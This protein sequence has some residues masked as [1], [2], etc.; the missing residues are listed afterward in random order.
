MAASA[1]SAEELTA[2]RATSII[3]CPTSSP[4][5][6]GCS[7]STC[8]VARPA[9]RRL[10]GTEQLDA[11]ADVVAGY[12]GA[13][14][15]GVASAG[16][17]RIWT[18]PNRSRA[19]WR[20]R[21]SAR[22]AADRVQVLTVHAAKGLEWQLVAVPHLSGRVFPSTA[23]ARTWLTDAGDL[24]PLLRGDRARSARTASRCSTPRRSTD[25]KQLSDTITGHRDELAQRRIDE[26]R[27]LLYV[28]ITRAEDTLLL[29]GHQWGDTELKPRGPSDFLLR[30]P[31]HHRGLRRHR[32]ACGEVDQWAPIRPDGEQNP[33]R[34]NV[35]ERVWPVDPAAGRRGDVVAVR[36]LW[37]PQAALGA[38]PR[39]TPGR[40]RRLGRRGRRAAGRARRGRTPPALALPTQLSVSSLVELGR[41]PAGRR[42]AVAPAAAGPSR[43]TRAAG[44]RLSRLG[45]TVLRRRAAASTSTTCPVP[46]T[47]TWAGPTPRS[48]P[49]CRPRSWRRRG[50][51]ARRSTSRC[52]SRW[53]SASTIV[54]GRI[55]AVFADAD[56]GVTVVDWKTGAT[57]GGR[58]RRA[59]RPRSSSPCTGWRGRRCTGARS[60][61]CGR[62]STTCAAGTPS[63]PTSC[64]APD[65]L[66]A[67]CSLCRAAAR[68][69]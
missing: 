51:R 22:R 35:I 34:D 66:V 8:E 61:R 46:W 49:N 33:L 19:A 30:G 20:P 12:A 9:V 65:E 39:P 16:C 63:Y 69:R 26:E 3:R 21:R 29:S 43:P 1:R 41:D 38:D 11:F 56:G 55:D 2:L 45:A 15:G 42:A 27:R 7:A 25:R 64:R 36:G 14:P 62:P 4:R 40:H 32:R 54:R 57:A 6:A 18:R 37:S 47:A 58:R 44:H 31:R 52:R 60:P 28:A 50:R 23:S 5:C 68:D 10:A 48:S 13:A 67:R 59:G 53:P 17:W 24:P